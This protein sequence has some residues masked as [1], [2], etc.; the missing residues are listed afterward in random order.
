MGIIFPFLF[1]LFSGS[2]CEPDDVQYVVAVEDGIIEPFFALEVSII[3]NA[4]HGW[5]RAGHGRFCQGNDPS[6]AILLA[7]PETTDSMCF[8]LRTM[9]RVSC[10]RNKRAIINLERWREGAAEWSLIGYHQYL[11]NHE[12][13]HVLEMGHRRCPENPN[14]PTPVMKQQSNSKIKCPRRGSPTQAEIESMSKKGWY[15]HAL[16]KAIINDPW[17]RPPPKIAKQ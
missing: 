1:R 15:F 4:K 17:E 8:P 12:V 10:A 13:G 6:F 11:I 2:P 7:K 9:E 16:R 5:T 14:E 3:L